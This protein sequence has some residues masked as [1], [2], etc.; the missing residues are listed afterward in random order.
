MR[1][2]ATKSISAAF[3]YS[4]IFSFYST[5]LHFTIHLFHHRR[6]SFITAFLYRCTLYYCIFNHCTCVPPYF[7]HETFS[8]HHFYNCMF[9]TVILSQY[10]HHCTFIN[11]LPSLY[12][13][14]S[15]FL[16]QQF[17]HC[18]FVT[19]FSITA[20]SSLTDKRKTT[21]KLIKWICWRELYVFLR[22]DVTNAMF[23]NMRIC[24]H[25]SPQNSAFSGA[26]SLNQ[27]EPHGATDKSGC[28]GGC[29]SFYIFPVLCVR[30]CKLRFMRENSVQ[31]VITVSH[32]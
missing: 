20:L 15:T 6:L 22:C 1:S 32:L 14:Y 4:S 12:F 27:C 25:S 9:I 29:F 26:R 24:A 3:I 2:W 10:F 16:P 11:V 19:V 21:Y 31:S 13:H 7:Y 8:S 5:C 17:H 23:N 28:S 30:L 18:T